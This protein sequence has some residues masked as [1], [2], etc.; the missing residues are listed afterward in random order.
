[1]KSYTI[2][3]L[4]IQLDNFIQYLLVQKYYSQQTTS[5]YRADVFHFLEFIKEVSVE[6]D[7]TIFRN[8]F[9]TLN[10]FK[11]S[12]MHRKM[13][14][15]K[16]FVKYMV[17]NGHDAQFPDQMYLPRMGESLPGVLSVETV[18]RLLDMPD[19]KTEYGL[20]DR[21]ILEILYACG[22][23]VS[24]LCSLTV[25]Q[26]DGDHIKVCGKGEKERY[27]PLP[28]NT[29]KMVQKYIKRYRATSVQSKLLFVTGKGKPIYREFVWK[30]VKQYAILAGCEG[31]CSPHTLRH[32]YATHMLQR[33]ADIRVIQ[34][35]LGHASINTTDIYTHVNNTELFNSFDRF[36]PD[37]D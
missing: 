1:M 3:Q 4:T 12:S 15:I 25:K 11:P 28:S 13:Q 17:K 8:Y 33:G 18:V 27:I 2:D 35:L 36:H 9:L 37:L 16:A 31:E 22:L 7:K 32:C 29:R 34:E 14:S 24:E 6:L 20:R 23:R 10:N 19:K 30:I 26:I 5:A 21:C